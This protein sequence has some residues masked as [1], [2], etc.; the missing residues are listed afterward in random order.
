MGHGRL[1]ARRARQHRRSRRTSARSVRVGRRLGEVPEQRREAASPSCGRIGRIERPPQV[2]E[3][4]R[5]AAPRPAP[6]RRAPAGRARARRARGRAAPT[7]SAS[8]AWR[9]A[10]L[11]VAAQRGDG[12]QRRLRDRAPQRLRACARSATRPRSPRR[13]RRRRPRSPAAPTRRA[14]APRPAPSGGPA[15][16]APSA[17][18]ASSAAARCTL[19]DDQ[20][21]VPEQ[22]LLARCRRVVRRQV[23]AAASRVPGTSTTT[24][25]CPSACSSVAASHSSLQREPAIV[26][27]LGERRSASSPAA[28]A[29]PRRGPARGQVEL[30]GHD[31]L[32]E[33]VGDLDAADLVREPGRGRE[34]AAARRPGRRQVRGAPQAGRRAF[35]VAGVARAPGDRLDLRRERG[36]EPG[37]GDDAVPGRAVRVGR[38]RPPRRTPRG[39]RAAARGRPRAAPRSASAD[40]RTRAAPGRRG[41]DDPPPVAA[42][43]CDRVQVLAVVERRDEPRDRGVGVGGPGPKAS[44]SAGVSGAQEPSSIPSSA[45]A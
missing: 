34:P 27:L 45:P 16:A 8:A 13:A 28:G 29:S 35:V 12:R 15:R 23:R 1:H 3:G 11:L 39:P 19:A 30:L 31:L 40:A 6:T 25:P 21:G 9:S 20:R 38:L 24:G 18:W 5:R 41:A 37:G 32:R 26:D 44:S 22:R 43:A 7:R 10:S 36:V 14:R 4:L 33:P 17:A 42:A 2:R